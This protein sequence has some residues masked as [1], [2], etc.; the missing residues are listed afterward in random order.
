MKKLIILLLL[1]FNSQAGYAQDKPAEVAAIHVGVRANVSLT[2]P[3]FIKPGDFRVS[4]YA[5]NNRAV[6]EP[7]FVNMRNEYAFGFGLSVDLNRTPY[8]GFD[9]E[10]IDA[11]RNYDTPIKV[12]WGSLDQSTRVETTS[13]LFG[14]RAFYPQS[15]PFR[16]YAS[17][18]LGY[19][20]TRMVVYGSLF[21]FPAYH[22]EYDYSF[23]PYQGA[24]ISYD[25][26]NWG[27]SANYRHY[28]VKGSFA[29]FHISNANLGSDVYLLGWHFR[30]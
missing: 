1:I 22:D 18:G 28:I 15:G 27:L 5:G 17:V 25:F 8:L 11:N 23:E 14:L 21:G 12:L 4:I 24:G 6:D 30:F 9:L 20:R 19:F 26:G 16:A 2:A 13:V 29:D 10:L 3:P 7:Q